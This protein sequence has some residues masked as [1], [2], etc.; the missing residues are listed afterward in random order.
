MSRA[1]RTL[2]S[3]PLYATDQQLGPAIL[4]P[5]KAGDWPQIAELLEGQ[6]LPKVDTLMGG[7]YVPAVKAFF[8]HENKLTSGPLPA[9]RSVENLGAWRDRKK[10]QRQA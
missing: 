2:D 7:R 10:S 5:V 9:P 3:L 1:T 6:G 8:D 4:G